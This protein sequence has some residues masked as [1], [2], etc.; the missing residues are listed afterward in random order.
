MVNTPSFGS[1]RFVIVH[2]NGDD[3]GNQNNKDPD[4]SPD[5]FLRPLATPDVWLRQGDVRIY[6]CP[7]ANDTCV[8]PS[9]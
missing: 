3:G 9:A 7:A 2:E 8:V 4:N 1:P 6:S 5:R